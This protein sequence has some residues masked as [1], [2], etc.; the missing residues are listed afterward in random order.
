[1]DL[2]KRHWIPGHLHEFQKKKHTEFERPRT[3][4]QYSTEYWNIP[5][6]S[7]VNVRKHNIPARG[8]AQNNKNRILEGQTKN[9]ND[10]K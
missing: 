3:N 4:T 7:I 8:I 1:M 5:V 9:K 10:Q 2:Q 6:E